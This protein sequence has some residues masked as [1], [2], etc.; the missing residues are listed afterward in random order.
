MRRAITVSLPPEVK[1]ELDKAMKEEGVSRSDIVRE[2]L[3][4]YLFIR[5]YRKLRDEGL[6]R[7]EARGVFT[8]E[9]VFESVS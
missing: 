6:G 9:D 1:Q 2:S 8:E 5:R 3:R 7:A 4:N